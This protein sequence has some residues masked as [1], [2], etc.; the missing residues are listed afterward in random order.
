MEGGTLSAAASKYTFSESHIAYV[1]REVY[2]YLFFLILE[3]AQR[4]KLLTFQK[5]GS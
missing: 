2:E 4:S 3:D 1:A 5:F